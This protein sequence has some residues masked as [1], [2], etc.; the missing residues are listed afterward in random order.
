MK[1]VRV[2][3]SIPKPQ[4]EQ[5]TKI[6]NKAKS[7]VGEFVKVAVAELARDPQAWRKLE[8]DG[9]RVDA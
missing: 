1:T 6:A 3:T 8:L 9:R 2:G 5:I 7:T 4:H